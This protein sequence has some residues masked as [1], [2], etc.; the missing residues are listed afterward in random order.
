MEDIPQPADEP[1]SPGDEVRIY[2]S[3]DD[4][5]SR[6]HGKTGRVVDVLTDS[7]SK[8]TERKLDSLSYSI[9]VNGEE[10]AVWFRHR[11]LVPNSPSE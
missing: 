7:L 6:Y 2:L 10:L 4:P 9:V 1:Y 3:K 5:D 11:D 8:E